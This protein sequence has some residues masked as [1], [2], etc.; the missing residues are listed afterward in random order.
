MDPYADAFAFVLRLWIEEDPA[1]ADAPAR[2]RGHITNVLD[3]R[4]CWV[5]SFQQVERFIVQY[6]AS[7]HREPPEGNSS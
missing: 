1:D 6:I 2:W 4:R 3:G 5:Q 7:T